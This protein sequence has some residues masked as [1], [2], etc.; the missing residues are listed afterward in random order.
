M[1]NAAVAEQADARD[2]KSLGVKSVSVQI[3]S[4]A[5]DKNETNP[6]RS[7]VC[8]VFLQEIVPGLKANDNYHYSLSPFYTPFFYAVLPKNDRSGLSGK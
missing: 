3:R 5:P 8:F 7:R 6:G 4:A 1:T 2:L